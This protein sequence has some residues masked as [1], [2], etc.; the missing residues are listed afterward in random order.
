MR[1]PVSVVIPHDARTPLIAASTPCRAASRLLFAESHRCLWLEQPSRIRSNVS[2]NCRQES[3]CRHVLPA[4][5]ASNEAFRAR[6]PS[7]SKSNSQEEKA[8]ACTENT[9]RMMLITTETTATLLIIVPCS[10]TLHPSLATWRASG[11]ALAIATGNPA[12]ARRVRLR[13][14]R[15]PLS[16]R[17]TQGTWRPCLERRRCDLSPTCDPKDLS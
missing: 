5:S 3:S 4:C 9:N 12:H 8:R 15:F 1:W 14:V 13:R 10:R 11:G 2:G 6:E 16:H 7:V 17:T